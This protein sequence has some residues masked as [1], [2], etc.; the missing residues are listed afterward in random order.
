MEIVKGVRFLDEIGQAH[1]G[2]L[3]R[4]IFLISILTL[5]VAI[6]FIFCLVILTLFLNFLSVIINMSGMLSRTSFL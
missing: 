5:F 3:A 6:V 2:W 4:L 1:S